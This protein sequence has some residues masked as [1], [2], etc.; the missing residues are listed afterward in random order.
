MCWFIF[1]FVYLVLNIVVL[2]NKRIEPVLYLVLRPSRYLL[3]NLWPFTSKLTVELNQST[4]LLITPFFLFNFRI[5]LIDET[6]SDLLTSFCAQSFRQDLPIFSNFLNEPLYGLVFFRW[7]YFSIYTQLG[8]SSVS[9]QALV[10]VAVVHQR[11][12]GWPFLGVLFIKP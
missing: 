2:L 9:V 11:S 10:L 1:A 12:N 8:E 5:K 3:A 6:L 7:P 4:I